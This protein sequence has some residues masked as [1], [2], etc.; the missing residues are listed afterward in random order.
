VSPNQRQSRA[1]SYVL[2]DGRFIEADQAFHAW[3][4]G[5][6]EKMT[7]A[8]SAPTNPVDRHFLLQ[9]IVEL[10]YKQ[11]VAPKMRQL[12]REVGEMHLREFTA[13]GPHL[14]EE[15]GGVMPRVTT[16]PRLA[17]VLAEDGDFE[18]AIEVCQI[19][20]SWGLRDGTVGGYTGR[21]KRLQ[22]A[23][24]KRRPRGA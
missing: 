12:C 7:Q 9:T 14:L 19:A 10:A 2:R 4:S 15:M 21:I 22:K 16:F 5:D 1:T 18:R 23:A 20:A 11:R 17:A 3:T 8:L 13:V 24:A 6:L